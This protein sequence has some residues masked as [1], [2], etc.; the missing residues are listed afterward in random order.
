MGAPADVIPGIGPARGTLK[1]RLPARL[2]FLQGASGLLL[3][4]FLWGHMLFVSSI[5]VSPDLMWAIARFF[6]GYFLLGRSV[7]LIVSGVVAVV[8][9][10]VLGHAFLAVRKLPAS[11]RQFTVYRE[12]MAL[13][14]HADTSLWWAQAV[15]GFA[16]F[17]LVAPHLYQMLMHPADIGPYESADRVFSGRWWP[18]YLVTLLCVEIHGGIGLYRLALKWGWFQGQD[19][20]RGRRRLRRLKWGLTAFLLTLGLATLGGYLKI[21]YQH[22]AVAGERYVPAWLQDPPVG[23]PPRWWPSLHEA[24]LP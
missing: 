12:H 17:F 3:V 13:M 23:T 10:L 5:L 11:Y 24:R 8:T 21:G 20:D 19:P 18:F 14:A 15:T 22:R 2:D 4:L 1:S 7:P 9:L 6:E 16:L